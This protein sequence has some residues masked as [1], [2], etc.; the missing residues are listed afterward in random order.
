MKREQRQIALNKQEAEDID[1][2]YIAIVNENFQ[3][4][5]KAFDAYKSTSANFW[6]ILKFPIKP[7]LDSLST[8]KELQKLSMSLLQPLSKNADV[9]DAQIEDYN[10]I[11]ALASQNAIEAAR[12]YTRALQGAQHAQITAHHSQLT[13]QQICQWL[14]ELDWNPSHFVLDA[15]LKI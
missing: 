7:K 4:F 3:L 12:D 9:V 14:G 10:R 6:S 15:L 2:V 8:A 5:E 13:I 11:A 1:D